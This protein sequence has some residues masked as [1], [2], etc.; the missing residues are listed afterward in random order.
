MAMEVTHFAWYH[1]SKSPRDAAGVGWVCVQDLENRSPQDT[2][3]EHVDKQ[4]IKDHPSCFPLLPADRNIA[5]QF[6]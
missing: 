6:G 4:E 3:Q 2:H 1:F 5:R